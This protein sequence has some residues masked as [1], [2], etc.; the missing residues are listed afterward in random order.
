MKTRLFK[1]I[2]VGLFFLT[3]LMTSLSDYFSSALF[4]IQNILI[5]LLVISFISFLY[6]RSREKVVSFSPKSRTRKIISVVYPIGFVAILFFLGN[7]QIYLVNQYQ[8]PPM[9]ACDV[10]D[11]SGNLIYQS[12]SLTCPTVTSHWSEAV[13]TQTYDF[14]EDLRGDQIGGDSTKTT[15]IDVVLDDEQRVLSWKSFQIERFFDLQNQMTNYV[16]Y[17]IEETRFFDGTDFLIHQVRSTHQ[18]TADDHND[19][20]FFMGNFSFSPEETTTIEY[21]TRFV[22]MVNSTTNQVHYLDATLEKKVDDGSS[23]VLAN[24]RYDYDYF[25]F[26]YT[27]IGSND[28]SRILLYEGNISVEILHGNLTNIKLSSAVNPSGLQLHLVESLTTRLT[29]STSATV[30]MEEFDRHPGIYGCGDL[31][32]QPIQMDDYELVKVYSNDLTWRGFA[33]NDDFFSVGF[34]DQYNYEVLLRNYEDAPRY[35]YLPNQPLIHEL[36]I[37]YEEIRP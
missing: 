9:I 5:Y 22:E 34:Y 29:D 31:I 35:F 16:I 1:I 11:T 30:T 12:A 10:Y 26:L 3:L 19:M 36:Y 7:L 37:Y 18:G 33:L 24:I 8:V 2:L 20:E 23:V 27:W 4:L 14:F 25:R 32:F 6:L 17:Q 13:Q 28:L 21:R 15:H